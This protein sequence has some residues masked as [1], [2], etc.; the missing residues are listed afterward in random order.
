MCISVPPNGIAKIMT[1]V[2][3]MKHFLY[4]NEILAIYML[5]AKKY[6]V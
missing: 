5:L 4:Y 1:G 3:V 2:A 6:L